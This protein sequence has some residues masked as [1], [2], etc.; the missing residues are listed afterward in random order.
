[1]FLVGSRPVVR[2]GLGRCLR[3]RGCEVIGE[4]VSGVDALRQALRLRPHVVVVDAAPGERAP[5]E[6][7]RDLTTADR[8]QRVLMVACH[9][10]PTAGGTSPEVVE[11]AWDSGVH[12]LVDA[13]ATAD[14]LAV[15]VDEVRTG[16]RRLPPRPSTS[17]LVAGT[18]V[19]TS[20]LMLTMREREVL[21]QIA[22]GYNTVEAAKILLL[23]PATVKHHLSAAHRKLGAR[24]RVEAVMLAMARGLISV[25]PADVNSRR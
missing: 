13:A 12:R 24:S 4:G 20:A 15:A 2:E 8:R 9:D 16:P 17:G 22:H 18:M 19:E 3:A 7:A 14:Q 23:S 1:M 6:L 11:R 10:D 5:F 21:T 25:D